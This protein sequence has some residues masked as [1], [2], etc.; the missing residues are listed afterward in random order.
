MTES[1][2][3][4]RPTIALSFIFRNDESTIA[5]ML[6]SFVPHVHEI[7]C[8]DTGCTDN[9]KQIIKDKL[10]KF[11]GRKRMISFEWVEDFAAA[12]QVGWD[13][14]EA[15]WGLWAD[16]DD[17]LVGGDSFVHLI[18][19]ADTEH[20][21]P[22]VG[23]FIF[24]YDYARTAEGHNV[25]VLPRERLVRMSVGWK[26][27]SPVHE[28]LIAQTPC[29]FV[30]VDSATWVH[31]KVPS[32]M[33]G[34]RNLNIIQRHIK[35]AKT[36]GVDP[37]PR[38]VAYLGVE[39]A[40]R[41]EHEDAIKAYRQYME[42]SGW[43]EEKH[44]VIHRMADS[45]RA[46]GLFDNAIECE[47]YALTHTAEH[48]VPEWPDHFFGIAEAMMGKAQWSQAIPWFQ[49]GMGIPM[50]VSSMILN[51]R[52]Y[53]YA[54]NL[55]LSICYFELGHYS[56][57]G[58]FAQIAI[59]IMPGEPRMLAHAHRVQAKMKEQRFIDAY[60]TV[61][62]NSIE[63]D[64]NLVA[65]NLIQNM[66]YVV[67]GNERL[68]QLGNH[69][70]RSTYQ[71]GS[72]KGYEHMYATNRE[73][74]NPDEFVDDASGRFGRAAFLRQGLE[75]QA[76]SLNRLPKYLDAGCNDGWMGA[77]M[78]KVGVVLEADGVDLNPVAIEAARDRVQRL[79]LHGRYETGFVEEA[80]EKF[81]IARYDAI[82]MF[83]VFEHLEDVHYSVGQL[84][85]AL[86]EG[87]V[88]YISTPAGAYEKG[89]I[90][91]AQWGANENKQ[92]LRAVSNNEFARFALQRGWLLG[93]DTG[94]Q[95]ITL[96]DGS[97]MLEGV[98]VIS[99]EPYVRKGRVVMYLGPAWDRW[100]PMDLET[101]GLGGSETAAIKLAEGLAQKGWFVDVYGGMT[102]EGPYNGVMYQNYTMYD[103]DEHC[104]VFISSRD[105]SAVSQLVPD[106]EV[107]YL[108]CHDA[109][110][111]GSLEKYIGDYDGI[112]TLTEAHTNSIRDAENVS[113]PDWDHL[114]LLTRNGIEHERFVPENGKS[115]PNRSQ[116]VIYSSSP[117]RGL[118]SLIDMW[119][120]I[121]KRVPTA[122]L[123][124]FYGFDVFD[125][126][127]KANPAM[128]AW[129][130]NMMK[131][132]AGTPGIQLFGRVDQQTLAN[133]QLR[134]RVWAYPYPQ[135]NPTETSCIT[136][137]ESMAAGLFC[138]TTNTGA[139]AETV[140]NGGILIDGDTKEPAYV[141]KFI[142]A[143]VIGLTNEPA[144]QHQSRAARLRS[145]QF[146]WDDVVDQWDTSFSEKLDELRDP[147]GSTGLPAEVP[148]S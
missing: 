28:V 106:A 21:H 80:S 146:S 50:P 7:V 98:Q 111:G 119:P 70:R 75:H 118:E 31:H 99:Y 10:A 112:F 3:A 60:V 51:P 141:N 30:N 122:L 15:D 97:V 38:M 53:D 1:I 127:H 108:W 27:A 39:L 138:V 6:D 148:A 92:H 32:E 34:D 68:F 94:N 26:W 16:A 105:A 120:Q 123:K 37:D 63:F 54:P 40:A 20:L 140:G 58:E 52:D 25:C 41:G 124:I 79:G 136:A 5:A 130:S 131:K 55:G 76:E 43:G 139:L 46:Q 66:P 107:K 23:G 82:S 24:K 33:Q 36:T 69:I 42:I 115:E 67:R 22:Q 128:L 145:E 135:N 121:K 44:Q 13:A 89:L 81:G 83:E 73:V 104:D 56:K 134:S 74:R 18:A 144:F 62:E 11:P 96:Q 132:I 29:Q 88:M 109:H 110:A 133:E 48:E 129:K 2:G 45:Y 100:S 113:S 102:T 14:I 72:V 84:E 78:E 95:P 85:Q 137:M 17:T 71:V 147:L 90:N 103:A 101:R 143:V 93:M 57:S 91:Q 142:E 117:D 59:D 65:R 64:E 114:F 8:V 125:Q 86:A 87:G 49:R 35:E 4:A 47:T 126:M 19:R 61:V 12:R 9:T 116:S 77:H